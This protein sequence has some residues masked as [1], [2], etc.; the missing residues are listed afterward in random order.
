LVEGK[1]IQFATVRS[2]QR[3]KVDGKSVIAILVVGV[4]IL[5]WLAYVGWLVLKARSLARSLM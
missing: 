5:A 3:T 1:V 4:L 2:K